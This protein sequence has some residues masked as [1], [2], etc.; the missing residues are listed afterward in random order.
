MTETPLHS[1]RVGPAATAGGPSTETD[2]RALFGESTAVFASMAGPAHL[3]E[4][5][6]PAFFTAIGRADRP[7]TGLPIGQLLPEL[8]EQGFLALLDR[9]YRTGRSHTGRDVRVVLG[10]GARAREAF[11]DFTYEPRRDKG[12]NVTGVRMIGVETTQVKHAQRLTAEHRVLLEQ[13]ARQAPL[14]EV[15]EGMARAIEELSPGVLVSVL[16]A[17]ED[18]RHLR[19]GTAPSL[20]AFYNRAI[21]GIATGEGVGSCGTAAHRRRRVIVSDIATDPS[22]DDF[23]DLAGRARL[24]ACWSTPIL[25]RDGRLLGTFAMYHRTPSSPSEADLALAGVFADTAALAIERHQVEQGRSAAEAREKAARDD[26]AFLLRAST[27]LSADLDHTE[28]LKRLATLCVPDLAP[29]SAVDVLETGRLRRV[30]TAAPDEPAR[31]LLASHGQD[32]PTDGPAARVLDSGLSEVA[33][34]PPTEAGPWAELDVTAYLCVP[35]TDGGRLFGTLTLLSTGGRTFDGRTVVLAE[36]LARRAASAARNALQYAQRAALARDLQAGL[37]LPDL[38]DLPGAEVATHYHPAGEGLE[39]GGDFYD[40][41]P[42]EGDRWAFML[43]DV[44]GRGARAAATTAL[45]RNTARAVAP[46]L[47]DPEAVVQAV[48]RALTAWHN[49]NG[50]GFVT[51]V[52]GHFVPTATGLDIELIRAGHTLPLHLTAEDTRPVHSEG[53]LLGIMPRPRLETRRLHLDPGQS[54]VLYTD[55]I[56]EARDGDGE[57]FGED[58]LLDALAPAPVAG[59]GAP[60]VLAT[61]VEAVRAFTGDSGTDDDQAVLVLTAT[62]TASAD[63]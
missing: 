15:L 35:L 59:R 2:L 9:V 5:A 50:T 53:L 40:V 33:R 19:H 63:G 13:I 57:Q 42:L 51:L 61:V 45:V 31:R 46:L 55:G 4:A 22:W 34:R 8:A 12:G 54:L 28:V 32:D 3:L 26:L 37:L 20:P 30:A 60:A 16:L 10:L 6:N 43:G 29:L 1:D 58:R 36:E 48:N 44:S 17:D 39:V 47:A 41:F 11:F 25:A 14:S 52:Y 21:D 24:A 27:A 49:Q 56:T 23:R 7:R 38:P 18:G 62:A